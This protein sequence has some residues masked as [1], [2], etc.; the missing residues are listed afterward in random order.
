[1]V[2]FIRQFK[3]K[4]GVKKILRSSTPKWNTRMREG[5]W[6]DQWAPAGFKKSE[7]TGSIWQISNWNSLDSYAQNI[8]K[9]MP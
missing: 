6:S 8:L 1:M 4:K 2:I 7:Q 9:C 5:T 3:E